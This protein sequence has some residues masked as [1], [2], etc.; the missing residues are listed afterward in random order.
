MGKRMR[1]GT[2]KRRGM[3]WE[4][5]QGTWA[6]ELKEGTR[7]RRGARGDER[8]GISKD[9]GGRGGGVGDKAEC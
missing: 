2:R 4:K 7:K 9:V 5:R 3:R 8:R 6:G 1:Q